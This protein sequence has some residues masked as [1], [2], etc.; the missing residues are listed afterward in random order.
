M[1]ILLAVGIM[2]PAVAVAAWAIC[3][4][5]EKRVQF[6][7]RTMMIGVTVV[8]FGLSAVMS[9]RYLN[10]ARIEWLDPASAEAG[11]AWTSPVVTR[12][13]DKFTA[14]YMPKFRSLND[15][16][17]VE[18]ARAPG[19]SGSFGRRFDNAKHV[20]QLRSSDE[21]YL[22]QWLAAVAKADAPKKGWFA[23]RGVVEDRDGQPVAD[24]MV[25]L[26]G[27]YVYI[28]HFQTREDGTFTM[29]IQAPPGRGYYLRVRYGDNRQMNTAQFTLADGN[30]ELVVRIRVK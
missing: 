30:R 8:A 20:L 5:R 3:V 24:A 19:W 25:D 7:L 10:L 15:L 11:F 17:D 22:R 9:W 23:I 18:V 4:R 1:V 26:M 28:N 2:L 12:E 13:G 16:G 29:P 21:S 27:S 14:V 6:S